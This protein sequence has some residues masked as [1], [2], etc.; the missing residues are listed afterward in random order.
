MILYECGL[1][2]YKG[3]RAFLL[4]PILYVSMVHRDGQHKFF[5][6]AK[7]DLSSG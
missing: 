7:K 4:Y 1:F 2:T 5:I 6:V 3:E